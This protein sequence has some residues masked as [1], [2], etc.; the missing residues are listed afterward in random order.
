MQCIMRDRPQGT[1]R[2]WEKGHPVSTEGGIEV[3]IMQ[4]VTEYKYRE[5]PAI[6]YGL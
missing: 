6:L 2:L 5:L 1:Y 4:N 3:L